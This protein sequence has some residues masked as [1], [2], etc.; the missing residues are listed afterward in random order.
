L[1]VFKANEANPYLSSAAVVA[2]LPYPGF[3]LLTDALPA[4]DIILPLVLLLLLLLL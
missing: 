3:S 4:A 2:N 1:K